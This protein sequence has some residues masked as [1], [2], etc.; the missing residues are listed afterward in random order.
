MKTP[1]R[2]LLVDD[3]PY[4]LDVAGDYLR[5]FTAFEVAG[6]AT[7]ALSAFAQ[8]RRLLPDVILLDLNLGT[9]S[10]IKLVQQFKQQVPLVKIIILSIMEESGYSAASL[11]AGADAFVP[12]SCMTHT[13]VQT[14]LDL[15][16][17]S[18]GEPAAQPAKTI[19][20]DSAAIFMRL[21]EQSNDLIYRYEFKPERGFAYA[22]PAAV[23]MTGYHPAEYYA[24]PDLGEKLVY[25]EDLPLWH[26]ILS[27]SVEPDRL[28]VLRLVRKDGA[29][30]WVEQ[31]TVRIFDETGELTAVEGIACDITERRLAEEAL[32]AAESRLKQII[33]SS[34]SLIYMTD[35]QGRFLL[36]NARLAD[37]F[38]K[39]AEAIHGM[40]REEFVPV[41]V[42]QEHRQ[43]DLKVLQTGQTLA[44]REENPETDGV[45]IYDSIK[46]PIRDSHNRVYAIGGI[47]A[48]ITE[49]NRAKQALQ[50]SNLRFSAIFQS[51]P[52]PISIARLSDSILVDVNAAWEKMTGYTRAEAL[53]QTPYALNL[54]VEPAQR[55]AMI[56]N[57]QT[58]GKTHTDIK[59][60]AKSGAVR[61]LLMTADRVEIM[62]EA[63]LL[64]M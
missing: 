17:G 1:I 36:A 24:D 7:D 23:A 11:Q 61:E 4:F 49:Q 20:P 45:H 54:W 18:S 52:A 9:Q 3:S 55:E 64:S 42:A 51:N 15:F 62:G 63:L 33:D 50:E 46:F 10:G 26:S 47:S 58:R 35:P 29:L 5:L 19:Y 44:I 25:P 43:N 6:T 21:A 39:P 48:D 41:S 57:L 40:R 2:I 8:A 60:R 27:G 53:G 16:N 22:S 13:L 14:I 34:S 31:R 56:Q 37:L 32:Q 28:A 12:K 38:G 59:I 30:L